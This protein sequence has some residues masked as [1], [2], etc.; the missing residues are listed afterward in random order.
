MV[1][2][3]LKAL[4]LT[5]SRS[6]G[7]LA[8]VR[9]LAS[10]GWVVGVGTPDGA[11]MIGRSRACARHHDV[12]RPRAACRGFVDAVG[13][14]VD[15]GGYHLVFGG[16]DD[17]VAALSESADR[18]PATVAH[19]TPEVVGR[20]FDKLELALRAPG[21]GWA[22][23]RTAV[24]TD[25]ALAA[26]GGP[27]VVKCRSHWNP[28]QQN[29]HRIEARRFASASAAAGHVRE[30]RAAGMEP[31]LQE[32]VSGGLEALI[33]IH[34]EGRLRGLV[35]QRTHRLWPTPNGVSARAETVAV[36]PA[37]V[38]R[39]EALLEELGWHGLAELQFLRDADGTPVLIDLN[40]RFYGSMALAVAAGV[41]L[42][43]A[44]ARLAAGE[45]MVELPEGIP[46][47]R[48][49]WG[50]GDVRRAWAERRPSLVADLAGTLRWAARARASVW[51]AQDPGPT[52]A[53]VGNRLRHPRG[54]RSAMPHEG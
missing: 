23:P 19:P 44:W 1:D 51:S 37:L 46:G 7:S 6:R 52:L 21:A 22:T 26:W 3:S 14:A 4:V 9:A 49:S 10:T 33:G 25:A 20:A 27:V 17:W 5:T 47:V 29:E 28:G 41:N 48:F 40:G 16:G 8:A 45:G 54:R 42:P 18:I 15:D 12:P 32:V 24:A 13:R 34:H 35:Q 43:D 38:R 31:L 39:A 11:G 53:L 50:A 2:R 30:V 36:D